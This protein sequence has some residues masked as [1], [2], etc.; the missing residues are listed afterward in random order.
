MYDELLTQSNELHKKHIR[1]R[2]WLRALCVLSAIVVFVTTYALILP[3]ITQ[4]RQ[5]FCGLIEHTHS[6]ACYK[7]CEPV[8]VCDLPEI[9]QHIHDHTCYND[10]T[11][12]LICTARQYELHTHTDTCYDDGGLVCEQKELCEHLHNSECYNILTEEAVLDCGFEEHTH[13][14]ECFV[15]TNA[16]IEDASVW[17]A[18]LPELTGNWSEDLV[19]IAKSQLG[20]TESELN[21]VIDG[22]LKRGYTRYG[23]WAEDPY[24]DWAGYFLD[25]CLSYAGI[26]ETYFPIDDDTELWI[27]TLTEASLY[28]GIDHQPKSGDLVFFKDGKV[29]IIAEFEDTIKTLEGDINGSVQYVT[30]DTFDSISGYGCLNNAYQIYRNEAPIVQSYSDSDITV[31]AEYPISADIPE[32]AELTVKPIVANEQ[33]DLRYD[34]AIIALE[35]ANGQIKETNITDFKLYDICFVYNGEE[36]QPGDSVDIQITINNIDVAVDN[37]ISV[38][39]FA[40]RGVEIPELSEC[41][42]GEEVTVG[43]SVDSFSEFAIVSSSQ[44]TLEMVSMTKNTSSRLPTGS[45][46]AI[47]S[48][49]HVLLAVQSEDGSITLTNSLVYSHDTD[50]NMTLDARTQQWKFTSVSGKYYVSTTIGTKNYY[51]KIES[52]ALSL[53]DTTSGATQFT[54]N[55]STGTLRLSASG[56]YIDPSRDSLLNTANTALAL[57]SRPTSGSFKVIFDAAIGNPTYMDGGGKRK[58]TGAGYKEITVS[59]GGKVV[60]PHN[61]PTSPDTANYI[62]IYG[63]DNNT[64]NDW[65]ELNGWYDV[66]NKVFYDRSMLGKE[67]TVTQST[68]F[69]PEYISKNYDA[70]YDNGHV[71]K[72][73]PDTRDFINTY[74]FD[75]NEIFNVDKANVT[76][77]GTSNIY[78]GKYITKWEVDTQDES[79]MVFFDYITTWVNSSNDANGDGNLGYMIGRVKGDQNGVTVNEEKTAGQRGSDTT[80]PGTITSNIMGP[81]GSSNV[82]N[83]RLDALFTKETIPGRVYLGEGDWFYNYDETIG[84]YYYNS[85]AN[86]AAY[87]QSEQ[88]FYVYDYPVRID[89][90]NSMHDFTPFTYRD[91]TEGDIANDGSPS[92][93]EKDNE[94]NYWVGMM[95]EIEFYLPED[96]G[97]KGNI[98]SHGDDLQFRFSGDDDVWIFVD[99]KLVVDLGGVHDVV[100]GEI[101]F[102]TGKI[103]T[104]QAFSSSQ[105][106]DNVAA[107]Y[108]EMPGLSATNNVGVTVTNLPKL[109]GGQYHTVTV[110]YLERGSALSNCAIYFNISPYYNLEITKQDDADGSLLAGAQFTVYEDKECTDI[111]S[112]YIRDENGTL[113][114][115]EAVFTTDENGKA[116]CEGLYAGKTYYIKE[117]KPPPGYPDMSAY[118]IVANLAT[119]GESVTVGVNSNG[120]EMIFSDAYVF[121]EEDEH[122]ILLNVYND[123]YVGGTKEIYTEKKWGEGSLPQPITVRVYANGEATARTIVLSEENGWKGSF[124]ELPEKDD[125][126]NVIVYTVKEENGPPRYSVQI[127]EITTVTDYTEGYWKT[128]SSLTAGKTYRFVYNGNA[129]KLNSSNSIVAASDSENDTSI[130]WN[131]ILA[132]GGFYLQNKGTPSRYLNISSSGNWWNTSYSLNTVTSAGSNSIFTLDSSRLKNTASGRYISAGNSY[133]TSTSGTRFTIYEWVEPQLTEIE[134]TGPGFRITNTP[135]PD[136]MS[137]PITKQ[138]SES[139]SDDRRTDA[140]FDLYL[141][142]EDQGAIPQ[143]VSS[144]TLSSTD[145]WQGSFTELE[146]PPDGSYYWITE[147]T[148][149]FIPIYTQPLTELVI[150]GKSISGVRVNTADDGN[151]VEIFVTNTPMILLPATGGK[152]ATHL[153]TIGGIL[154]MTTAVILLVY[155]SRKRRLEDSGTP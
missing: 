112:L 35:A 90:N 137:I 76:Y 107:N 87:N 22:D 54:S 78:N 15:D 108:T 49:G 45:A 62:S 27:D 92:L 44:N 127:D 114:S 118:I 28:C 121:S 125:D 153:Y 140:V 39:H 83:P 132:N 122:L 149:S 55:W 69:Y 86:A 101:N 43:F 110:Y 46:F 42:I 52:G 94:V 37:E 99:G 79:G 143:Y 9:I 113:M 66:I 138:W 152:G 38:V 41:D 40:D 71:I 150:N 19:A 124:Y 155:N 33:Y 119:P 17:E 115:T 84:F 120:E 88:R 16:D 146:H 57:Y 61:D 75:Y 72:G 106:A 6:D 126:G 151:A 10:E 93:R 80:F 13:V 23:Q 129:M 48:A 144:L 14:E 131:A 58:Y 7:Q 31:R 63:G 25:F 102:A 67:I 116:R 103:K 4:E 154:L 147:N 111:A 91:T 85:A 95:S 32:G 64:L 2:R 100:Y 139:I 142:A 34:E 5:S 104:G 130:Q 3:G 8:L 56:Y 18:T 98:S 24:G 105:V 81:L 117:T 77:F 133:S 26:D 11:N 50:N 148:E 123:K 36:I 59:A 97:S 65:Y 141:V 135:W 128:V 47:A 134:L 96:S 109:E 68:I 136:K 74:M 51:L 30:Y 145:N 53:T 12:E 82:N 60:L 21:V 73:Q 70:G 29:A 1:R 89:N 20:Y